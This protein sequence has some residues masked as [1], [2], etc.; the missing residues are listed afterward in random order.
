MPPT[1]QQMDLRNEMMHTM[2]ECGIDIEA[3]H[4]EVATGGQAEIDMKFDHLVAMA[5]KMMMY[6]Y[7]CKDVARKYGKT[8]TFMPKPL[9]GDNGSG[10]PA[11]SRCGAA[12]THCSPGAATPA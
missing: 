11:T 4:H 9:F 5:D 10:M 12:A 6:K 2:I 1:D 7:I 3:Q 8:V